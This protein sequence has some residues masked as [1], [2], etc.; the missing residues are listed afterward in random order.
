MRSVTAAEANRSSSK[1]LSEV[2]RGETVTITS[3]GAPIAKLV[4]FLD[5]SEPERR[6]K[7]KQALLDRWATLTPWT[8]DRWTRDDLYED[9][10]KE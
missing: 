3:H 7:A 10:P 1:L 5:A 4:P 6:E 2:K 8:A 9:D